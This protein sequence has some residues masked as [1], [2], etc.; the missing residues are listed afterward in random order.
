MLKKAGERRY[1]LY[2]DSVY[3]LHLVIMDLS[4]A[5][6]P[7][8]KIT[9]ENP[10][11]L[12][13]ETFGFFNRKLFKEAGEDF[14]SLELF[15]FGILIKDLKINEDLKV[16]A[17]LKLLKS[18]D[19]FRLPITCLLHDLNMLK[20]LYSDQKILDLIIQINCEKTDSQ[21][22]GILDAGLENVAA[23]AIHDPQAVE[24]MIAAGVGQEVTLLL[25]GKLDMP[26]I[27]RKGE[28]LE[29]NGRVKLIKLL[30]Y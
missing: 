7:L 21:L 1:F 11:Q 4:N 16:N 25:G 18:K 10:R 6:Y 22:K 26:S 13:V 12:M 14:F 9:Y 28:P 8:N 5:Q 23:F 17:A 24:Q 19:K 27:N 3:R 15:Y 30:I 29:V 20:R 2:I